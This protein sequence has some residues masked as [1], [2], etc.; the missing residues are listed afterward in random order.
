M[1]ILS[2]CPGS[3]SWSSNKALSAS[4]VTADQFGNSYTA[5]A[6][7][8]PPTETYNPDL[9]D[10]FSGY[11]T[12][13][14]PPGSLPNV[15][16]TG[17]SCP[18]G[19]YPSSFT[20]PPNN[21]TFDPT[22]GPSQSPKSYFV[23]D[24]TVKINGGNL[25]FA[26]EG[27][28]VTKVVYWFR[29]GLTLTGGANVS[30]G[31]ATYIFGDSSVSPPGPSCPSKTLDFGGSATVAASTGLMFYVEEG[32]ASFGSQV[33]T[34]LPGTCQFDPTYQLGTPC[35]RAIAIWDATSLPLSLGGGSNIS[36]GGV[37]D[38]NGQV[39]FVGGATITTTFVIVNS[40]NFTGNTGLVVGG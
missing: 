30:F 25:T 37:Y 39:T 5:S 12:P 26:G 3:I 14:N 35:T 18:T 10:P 32:C 4:I 7:P 33:G 29:G 19:Q 11:I 28:D 17:N 38:P 8:T 24:N 27:T 20:S 36:I 22:T 13:V 34:G 23:F 2:P 1:G 40:A 21:A 9:Q 31:P 16:C 15:G 6:P